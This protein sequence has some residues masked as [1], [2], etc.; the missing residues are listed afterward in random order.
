MDFLPFDKSGEIEKWQRHLP[1][2]EQS[3]RTY[4]VT[5]RLDDSI[6]LSKLDQW[7]R[8]KS[9]WETTHPKPWSEQEW[10]VYRWEFLERIERWSDAGFGDCLLRDSEIRKMVADA[11]WFFDAR[12]G[13][14]ETRYEIGDFVIMPNHVHLLVR[15]LREWKLGQL[16]H[17]WKSFTAHQINKALNRSGSLWMDERFDH[18][19]RNSDSLSKFQSYIIN[20]P[21]KAGLRA[22]EY[23]LHNVGPASP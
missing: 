19:V 5:F 13:K 15:P 10:K 23:T 12:F 16:V 1:H 9:D 18:L 3:G 20:N 22:H 14:G 6:P 8:E 21:L 4:F 11:F 2:W 17:S 7:K